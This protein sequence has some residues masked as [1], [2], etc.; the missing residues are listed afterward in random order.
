MK[1]TVT[2]STWLDRLQDF[3]GHGPLVHL[4]HANGFPPGAYRPLIGNLR[5]HHQV[6][7]LTTRPLRPGSRPENAP[8]W[9]PLADDLVRG[10]DALGVRRIFGVGHSIGGV[11]TMWAAVRRPDLFRALVL[12]DPVILPPATLWLLRLMRAVGLE[13]RQ[14]LVRGALHRRRTWPDRQACFQHYRAKDF[15]S[16]WSDESLW[17]YVKAGTRPT[18][19]GRIELTYP[20]EWE[21]HIFATS[22]VDV[23]QAVPELEVPT[24]VIRGQETN[25]FRAASHRR[26]ARLVPHAC[27]TVVPEAGHLVPMERPEE[28]AVAIRRFLVAFETL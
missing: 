1:T 27:F 28:T 8:S 12:I 11:L 13:E 7:A 4:A 2:L 6:V 16:R 9:H 24:L 5:A 19:N 18:A 10:L 22:P 26:F 17:A 3:G 23:W 25:T 15:F 21:A 14:P 20:P